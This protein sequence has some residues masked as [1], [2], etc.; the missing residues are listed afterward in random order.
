MAQLVICYKLARDIAT[1]SSDK[2]TETTYYAKHL[3]LTKVLIMALMTE[4]RATLGRFTDAA[5]LEQ[6][7]DDTLLSLEYSTTF[8][9]KLGSNFL[10]RIHSST[11]LLCQ[12]SHL[13]I[14][15]MLTVSDRS[16][17]W[18]MTRFSESYDSNDVKSNQYAI[19]LGLLNIKRYLMCIKMSLRSYLLLSRAEIVVAS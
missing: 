5:G 3:E 16:L 1:P 11:E 12:E 8:F 18:D 19:Q 2:A 13:R 4:R 15:S 10:A 7:K 14:N 9:S 17:L 6:D